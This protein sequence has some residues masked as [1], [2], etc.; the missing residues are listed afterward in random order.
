M[1]Q[2][3]IRPKHDSGRQIRLRCKETG[4]ERFAHFIGGR[5]DVIR[6]D[7]ADRGGGGLGKSCHRRRF[8]RTGADHRVS[9]HERESA[10]ANDLSCWSAKLEM[11]LW[12][13]DRLF[14]LGHLIRRG[15]AAV[16]RQVL[17][18]TRQVPKHLTGRARQLGRWVLHTTQSGSPPR[19]RS[20]KQRH[21]CLQSR[22]KCH[23]IITSRGC[24]QAGQSQRKGRLAAAPAP[25]ISRSSTEA[26]IRS[27]ARYRSRRRHLGRGSCRA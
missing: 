7:R 20:R 6:C 10:D 22:A 23:R 2:Q 8:S 17:R 21:I 1:C 26:L 9:Q 27:F 19:H 25:S 12:A 14:W 4:T 16:R 5:V 11:A 15:N 13:L 18:L 24:G 3:V